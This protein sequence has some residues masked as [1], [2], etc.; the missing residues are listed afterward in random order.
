MTVQD[1]WC[2]NKGTKALWGRSDA[3]CWVDVCCTGIRWQG[4]RDYIR[5]Y[6]SKETL[7]GQLTDT[8]ININI[9]VVVKVAE[10][11]TRTQTLHHTVTRHFSP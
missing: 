11:V 7:K 6:G 4:A 2:A 9:F 10:K 5:I 1:S 8:Y 3:M